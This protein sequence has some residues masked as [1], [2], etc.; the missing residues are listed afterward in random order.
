MFGHFCVLDTLHILTVF[1]HDDG[2]V[3]FL[4][5]FLMVTDWPL[6]LILCE[7]VYVHQENTKA[8]WIVSGQVPDV[9]GCLSNMISPSCFIFLCLPIPY[10]MPSSSQTSLRNASTSLPC[11]LWFHVVGTEC[12]YSWTQWR[13]Q[14][15]WEEFPL[16]RNSIWVLSGKYATM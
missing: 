1:R 2:L 16:R 10:R 6:K 9:R 4:S 7:I 5:W 11:L 13:G 14:S 3:L 15:V 12:P 8:Q